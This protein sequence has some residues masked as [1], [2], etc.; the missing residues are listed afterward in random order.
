MRD[1]RPIGGRQ[2]DQHQ[3]IGMPCDSGKLSAGE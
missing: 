1:R 3:A 2:I